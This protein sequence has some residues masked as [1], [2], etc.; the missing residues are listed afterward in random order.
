MIS[1]FF[2]ALITNRA[3][4]A[5][6][7]DE[8]PIPLEILFEQPHVN[9]T[10]NPKEMKSLFSSNNNELLS[11]QQVDTLNQNYDGL[12]GIMFRDG[13]S[14]DFDELWNAS[15]SDIQMFF[16]YSLGNLI[17]IISILK[18]DP[19]EHTSSGH[20]ITQRGIPKK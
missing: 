8:N 9:W 17:I 18:S 1:T 7:A 12:G 4:L 20:L 16:S 6:W 5:H 3:Y 14:Q 2:Y 11:F 10:Y 15:V 13:V 19:T